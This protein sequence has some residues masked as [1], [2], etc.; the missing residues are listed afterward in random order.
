LLLHLKIRTVEF[1]QVIPP[2]VSVLSYLIQSLASEKE[3]L[4][5]IWGF[6][7]RLCQV[8]NIKYPFVRHQSKQG[9]P[10]MFI[11][12]EIQANTDWQDYYSDILFDRLHCSLKE[13]P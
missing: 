8:F 7:L 4:S 9:I 10:N 1:L 2:R 5:L 12:L 13:L 3:T 11:V 6:A